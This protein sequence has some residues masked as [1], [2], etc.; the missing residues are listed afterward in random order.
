MFRNFSVTWTLVA[1]TLIGGGVGMCAFVMAVFELGDP[2]F[3][4]AGYFLGAL[5]GGYTVGRVSPG[6]T[7][8]EPA[9][10]GFLLTGLLFGFFGLS[11]GSS[12]IWKEGTGAELL[13]RALSLGALSLLGGLVGALAGER[14]SE[15]T[16]L[17]QRGARH[18]IRH[19]WISLMAYS[20]LLLIGGVLFMIA[21]QETGETLVDAPGLFLLGFCGAAVGAGV[22][23]QAMSEPRALLG[24]S[25]GPL[26]FYLTLGIALAA[27]TGKNGSMVI[28]LALGGAVPS[29]LALLGAA[30]THSRMARRQT[31][32]A[33]PPLA[34]AR[35]AE[36]AR[37]RGQS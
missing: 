30:V 12:F 31:A 29:L 23:A 8:A 26:L 14:K 3:G 34:T 35:V 27:F 7:V 20:G 1:F 24:S 36:S 15:R 19:M 4:H 2:W 11:P 9:V 37:T 16:P 21:K 13:H 25:S 32:A 33:Q 6:I 10:G 22:I 28:F 17:V 18:L 5:I